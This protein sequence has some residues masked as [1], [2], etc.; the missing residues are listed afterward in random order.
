MVGYNLVM[1]LKLEKGN[2]F[3]I[4]NYC[5]FFQVCEQKEVF[6]G[7]QSK[8]EVI[9][10]VMQVFVDV[11]IYI[12]EYRRLMLF[13]R[14]VEI[15]GGDNFLWR[16]VFL[17]MAYEIIRFVSE[18]IEVRLVVRCY[19]FNILQFLCINLCIVDFNKR[20]FIYFMVGR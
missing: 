6:V 2:D 9:I 18:F 20:L 3:M 5:V 10:M 11:Y 14:L 19:I 12:S 15:V 8:E 17:K 1:F 16:C 7:G 13:L 4:V